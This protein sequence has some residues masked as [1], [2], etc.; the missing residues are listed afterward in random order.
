METERRKHQE[1]R[2][3]EDRRKNQDWLYFGPE[4]RR[5]SDDRRDSDS[6]RRT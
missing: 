1:R 6:D 2:V 3:N 5:E 4:R